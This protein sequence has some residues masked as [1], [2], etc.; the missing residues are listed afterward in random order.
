MQQILLVAVACV[1]KRHV[2]PLAV[3]RMA[4]EVLWSP[5][6]TTKELASCLEIGLLT[7]DLLGLLSVP[8]GHDA[9]SFA[10]TRG[11]KVGPSRLG[12]ESAADEVFQTLPRGP[13]AG[14]AGPLCK[15]QSIQLWH[16]TRAPP[17]STDTREANGELLLRFLPSTRHG[18]PAREN[19]QKP[20]AKWWVSFF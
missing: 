4:A 6:S 15:C 12:F 20:P 19:R 17:E 14:R 2:E 16:P 3:N 13:A 5:A 9:A 1:R 7:I 10:R 11:A 8:D 18:V